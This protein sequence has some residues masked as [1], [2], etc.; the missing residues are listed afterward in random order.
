MS[1]PGFAAARRRHILELVQRNGWMA[2]RDLA[3]AVGGSDVT[4]RRDLRVLAEQGLLVRA[5]G[6]AFPPGTLAYEPSYGE[7]ARVAGAEKEA[8]AVAAAGMVEDG[9]T[10]VLGAGTTT[11]RLAA[12]LV[13]R[14]GLTV[15]TNSLAVAHTLARAPDVEVL[16]TGGVLRG[17]IRAL[18][19]GAAEQSLAGLRARVAFLSGN[20]LTAE[21]GLSTP[22]MEVAMVDRA[23][24]RAATEVVVL[25]DATKVGVEA[26]YQ[27]VPPGLM[28]ALVSDAPVA[29]AELAALATGGVRVTAV[30][31]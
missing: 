18:V 31:G 28:S 25:A 1:G 6:G 24:A 21:R 17:S 19:G 16:L 27:T 4:V 12:H 10:V 13:A 8:I 2:L 15:V 3:T 14:R 11:E 22:N 23:L 9:D 7:K 26:V 5:R 29:G 20:G 30:R